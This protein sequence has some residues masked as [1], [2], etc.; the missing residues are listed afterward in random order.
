MDQLLYW[1]FGVSKI[2]KVLG[3]TRQLDEWFRTL[4]ELDLAYLRWFERMGAPGPVP[5]FRPRR[6][7]SGN[8]R[9]GTANGDIGRAVP[10]VLEGIQKGQYSG[11][12]QK[13]V[14]QLS[15]SSLAT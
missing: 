6:S 3:N 10:T 15:K 4:G 13:N 2:L 8:T 11:N 5:V 9:L 14:Q 1:L 12:I 7:L